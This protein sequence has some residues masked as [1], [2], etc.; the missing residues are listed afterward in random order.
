MY[1]LYHIE[2]FKTIKKYAKNK[3]CIDI[4]EAAL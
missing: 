2:Q 3:N 1:K 4:C